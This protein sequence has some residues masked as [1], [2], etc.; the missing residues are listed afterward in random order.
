M[1]GLSQTHLLSREKSDLPEECVVKVPLNTTYHLSNILN[2]QNVEGSCIYNHI[3]SNLWI[4]WCLI[5]NFEVKA[6]RHMTSLWEGLAKG[7]QALRLH[8]ISFLKSN[9]RMISTECNSSPF[10]SSS[11]TTSV[12]RHSLSF[13]THITHCL[14]PSLTHHQ[15]L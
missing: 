3:V 2:G 1:S 10:T 6:S 11:F 13:L 5:Q 12:H 9:T 8:L 7:S 14:V 15:F 4:S